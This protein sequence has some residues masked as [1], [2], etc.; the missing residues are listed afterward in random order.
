MRAPFDKGLEQPPRLIRPDRLP[1]AI[2]GAVDCHPSLRVETKPAPTG[3]VV[4][5]AIK[6][7]PKNYCSTFERLGEML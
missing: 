5:P 7:T 2:A 6:A 3:Q 1:G 4:Q